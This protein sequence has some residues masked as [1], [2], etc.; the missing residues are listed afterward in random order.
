MARRESERSVERMQAQDQNMDEATKA[1]KPLAGQHALVTGGNRGI[2]A[3]VADRLASLGAAITLVARDEAALAATAGVIEKAHGVAVAQASADVTDE[4]AAARAFDIARAAN[5]EV[6]VLV[7]NAGTGKSAPFHRTEPDLW[8]A[9]I[10][11]N[12]TSVYLFTRQ[13][14]PAMRE[15]GWGR[16]VNVASSAGLVGYRYVSAYVAAK[17]GVVGLTRSLALE[18]ALKG[19]TVNAICPGYVD[20]EMTRATLANIVDKTGCSDE[21]ALAQLTELNPQGRLITPQEVASTVAWL[22]LPEQASMTGQAIAVAG[23]EVM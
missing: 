15:A 2:G 22:A 16:I 11:I 19:I 14:L 6:T 10:D 21:E 17:H 20:T 9:M 5:G 12:L 8:R 7:N 23:G 13:A 18:T 3:A 4:A 1:A